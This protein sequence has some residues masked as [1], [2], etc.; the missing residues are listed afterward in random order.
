MEA[1]GK[2]LL[3]AFFVL[4]MPTGLLWGG[5]WVVTTFTPGFAAACATMAPYLIW[6][7]VWCVLAYIALQ[8]FIAVVDG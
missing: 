2:I 3:F 7:V 6:I 5:H 8:I 4:A 1:L